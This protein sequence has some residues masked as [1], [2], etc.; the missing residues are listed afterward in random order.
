MKKNSALSFVLI[1]AM[2]FTGLIGCGTDE[3][4]EETLNNNVSE[5]AAETETESETILT[6][7]LPAKNFGNEDFT[8]LCRTDKSYEFDISEQ[9]GNNLQDAVYYRNLR[10]EER[11]EVKIEPYQV[12]GNWGSRQTFIDTIRNEATAGDGYIDLIAGYCAY[13][14]TVVLNG[15]CMNLY[16]LPL[17][18][19]DNDW[20]YDGFNKNMSI[21][22]KLYMGLGDASLTMW[23]D[24]QVVFFNKN[25]MTDYSL[26]YPYEMVSAGTWDFYTLKEYCAYHSRD[27]DNNSAMNLSDNWGMLFYNKRDLMVYFENPYTSMDDEGKP[28]ISVYNDRLVDI[29]DTIYRFMFEDNLGRQFRPDE[30]SLMFRED[31]A[32]FLQAPLRYAEIF[33]DNESDFGI[34]PFPKYDVSQKRYYTPVVDD[35]SVFCVPVTVRDEELTA[36]MLEALNFESSQTVVPEYF[37]VSLTRKNFRDNESGEMLELIR[38]SIWF[39]FGFVY[40]D[41][42]GKLGLILD[43]LN[44]NNNEI[45]SYYKR[46]EKIY[47]N[48]LD[49]LIEFYYNEE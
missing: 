4:S 23:E 40:Q 5:T 6:D 14:P 8:I 35:L 16:E 19:F 34:I 49:D 48:G 29:Y 43:C 39:E 26:E 36:Y 1:S 22:E 37:E 30:I 9:T 15:Y 32:M 33:R 21:N 42:L 25:M 44:E 47:Q 38:D 28:Y 11:Y 46:N 2:L 7:G 27:V 10:V 31:K 13:M 20:W 18:D 24:L 45:A 17:V 3:S 12:D 41:N